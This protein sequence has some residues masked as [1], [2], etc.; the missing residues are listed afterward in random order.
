MDLY[1]DSIS[2]SYTFVLLFYKFLSHHTYFNM[3]I[4]CIYF[5]RRKILSAVRLKLK[6]KTK[7]WTTIQYKMINIE[8]FN[9]RNVTLCSVWYCHAFSWRYHQYKIKPTDL[10]KTWFMQRDKR[11]KTSF[12]KSIISRDLFLMF[13]SV[14]NK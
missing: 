11:H 13:C 9:I 14:L 12:N 8:L 7:T 4:I 6:K 3:F 10:N 5:S 1:C 2:I